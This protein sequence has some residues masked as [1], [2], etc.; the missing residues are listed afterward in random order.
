M[1]EPPEQTTSS[2]RRCRR[3]RIANSPTP[4]WQRQTRWFAAEFMVVVTGVLMALAVQAW[5]QHQQDR[6]RE[7]SYLRQISAD[8]EETER[9][10]ARADS[11]YQ[12]GDQAITALLSAYQSAELP[13]E[14]SVAVWIWSSRR[15]RAPA[16]VMETVESLATTGE[17]RLIRDDSLRAAILSYAGIMRYNVATQQNHLLRLLAGI[18]RTTMMV[19]MSAVRSLAGEEAEVDGDARTTLFPTT[20][21][22]ELRGRYALDVRSLFDDRATYASLETIADARTVLMVMRSRMLE[23]TRAL[24]QQIEPHVE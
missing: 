13:S 14:D 5:Y 2:A 17:L 15:Y 3:L 22:G 18:D 6:G 19:S 21:R 8:L 16:P 7:Q 11:V 24:R 12:R 23:P 9:R 1:I 4:G 10:I 20:P